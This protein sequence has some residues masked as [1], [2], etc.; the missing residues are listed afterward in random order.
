MLVFVLGTLLSFFE[1]WLFVLPINKIKTVP[2]LSDPWKSVLSAWCSSILLIWFCLGIQHEGFYYKL[3]CTIV[4]AYQV[5]N[6]L[7][8]YFSII[9][10]KEMCTAHPFWCY[11]KLYN[12][13][14]Y[15]IKLCQVCFVIIDLDVGCCRYCAWVYR[16]LCLHFDC[17]WN[18]CRHIDI[19][20]TLVIFS[21]GY[22]YCVL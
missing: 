2:N 18:L 17:L 22:I 8:K 16:Y 4:E 11:G 9:F 19:I 13:D 7:W 1:W 21:C 14:L 10:F 6:F 20:M 5:M 3:L 15:L 12:Y